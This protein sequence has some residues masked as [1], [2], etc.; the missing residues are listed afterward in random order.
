MVL[1]EASRKLEQ[2]GAHVKTI[3]FIGSGPVARHLAALAQAAGLRTVLSSRIPSAAQDTTD[4]A[5]A[6]KQGDIV[7]VAI[8]YSATAD[9]LPDLSSLLANKIVIDATNPLQPD[10]TPIVL[11][12]ETS[13]GE[14]VAKL[15]SHSTTVKAFNTIFADVMRADRQDRDGQRATAFIA[16]DDQQARATIS[17]LAGSLGFAPIQTGPLHTARY[18]EALAHLNIQIAFPEGGGSNAAFVY[19]QAPA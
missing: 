8:P 2:N 5:E 3:A 6:A 7:V 12:A 4:F 13:A 1:D 9:V 15:L 17:E 11:G 18:L 16:S 19:H 14:E 10:Y